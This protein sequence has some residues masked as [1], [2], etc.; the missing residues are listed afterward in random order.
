MIAIL[1]GVRIA[2]AA[3]TFAVLADQVTGRLVT[4]PLPRPLQAG[5]AVWVKVTVGQIAHSAEI[6]LTTPAGRM[7]GVISPHGIQP[8]QEPGTYTVPVP[9][10]AISDNRVSLRLAVD[11]GGHARRAA[12]RQEVKKIEVSVTRP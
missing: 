9:A 1:A 10:D 12:T 7:V 6:V 4:L 3:L 2:V 5:D 8:G 11:Q